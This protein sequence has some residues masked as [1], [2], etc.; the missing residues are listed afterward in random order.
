M[1]L[2][3]LPASGRKRL[4]TAPPLD[5][6]KREPAAGSEVSRKPPEVDGTDLAPSAVGAD[7]SASS[8]MEAFRSPWIAVTERYSTLSAGFDRAVWLDADITDAVA[9]DAAETTTAM[10][11]TIK[12]AFMSNP[13]LRTRAG[14]MGTIFR[15]AA[16][17]RAVPLYGA[18]NKFTIVAN[19]LYTGGLQRK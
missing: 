4:S 3:A 10:V 11:R 16:N 8:R 2:P 14:A 7:A 15:L 6:W 18:G 19:F 9:Y 5:A 13:P 1:A 17:A 12:R